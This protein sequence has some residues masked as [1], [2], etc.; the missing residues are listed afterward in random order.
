MAP[1]SDKGL[2]PITILMADDDEDDFVITSSLI[3]EIPNGN[4]IIDWCPKH[5]DALRKI[6]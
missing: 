2:K 5:T 3:K 4:F 6:L 1:K